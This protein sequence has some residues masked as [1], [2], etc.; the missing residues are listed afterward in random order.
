M[1]TAEQSG[2][3]SFAP[4]TTEAGGLHRKIDWKGA[5]WIA[6]GVPALVLISIGGMG[7]AVGKLAFVA[8]TISVIMGFFQAF[9]GSNNRRLRP[10]QCSNSEFCRFI[11]GFSSDRCCCVQLLFPTSSVVIVGA[12]SGWLGPL[13][14]LYVALRA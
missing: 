11:G 6:S 5:H 9:S 10:K 14:T 3:N 12:G 4:A 1:A 8:W 2:S 7:A 13:E